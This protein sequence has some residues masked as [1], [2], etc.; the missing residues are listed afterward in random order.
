MKFYPIKHFRKGN[1]FFITFSFELSILF[2]KVNPEEQRCM[3]VGYLSQEGRFSYGI[4]ILKSE[5]WSLMKRPTASTKV[6]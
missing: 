2:Q 6:M 1:H 5:H 4:L 3:L